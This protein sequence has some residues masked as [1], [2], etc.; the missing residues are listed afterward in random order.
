MLIRMKSCAVSVGKLVVAGR[1]VLK[2]LLQDV[3]EALFGLTTRLNLLVI[4]QRLS[5]CRE[6]VTFGMR[7][8]RHKNT[9]RQ[10]SQDEHCMIRLN[11]ST[12]GY[13]IQSCISY[14]T[15][16]DFAV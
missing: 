8:I 16:S 15:S 10:I 14:A 5:C 12:T 7:N 6:H 9:R 13:E 2:T 11:Y 1:L 4:R 3:A